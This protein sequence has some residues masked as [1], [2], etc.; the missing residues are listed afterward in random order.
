VYCAQ[1]ECCVTLF[2]LNVL[3]HNDSNSKST[4]SQRLKMPGRLEG[5]TAI[6]TGA[7]MGLGEGIARKFVE[8]GANVLLFEISAD[9]GQKVAESLPKDKASF[10]KGD[11]TNVDDWD[12]ALKEATN[13]FGGLDIVVNN[14]G[15]V[16]RAGVCVIANSRPVHRS[17]NSVSLLTTYHDRNMVS[18]VIR[19][20][21]RLACRPLLIS[22]ARS[23][24]VCQYF[25]AV[26]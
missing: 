7:G 11:V 18:H 24:H 2:L 26:Q 17:A 22:T 1:D 21:V 3:P 8:E 19:R 9:H 14:A 15:V 4:P 23:H 5:K 25:A 12:G 20:V 6:I 13:K 16:H 10:F